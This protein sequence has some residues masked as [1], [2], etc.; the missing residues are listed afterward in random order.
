VDRHR[1]ASTAGLWRSDDARLVLFL[2]G[3]RGAVVAAA[4]TPDGR[5]ILTAGRD[6]TV[7]RYRCELRGGIDELVAIAKARLAALR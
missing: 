3:H 1:G 4:F 2:H 6:G 7:R 5:D